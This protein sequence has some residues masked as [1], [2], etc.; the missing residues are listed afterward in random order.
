MTG[1]SRFGAQ[2]ENVRS[3]IDRSQ[4]RSDRYVRISIQAITGEGV[5]R[6]VED[7]H[8]VRLGAPAQQVSVPGRWRQ[9][10]LCF[11]G[12]TT[13]VALCPGHRGPPRTMAMNSAR[14][15]GRLR[16]PARIAE[17]TIV[18]PGFSMPRMVMQV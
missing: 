1:T 15:S 10:E 3:S 5:G 11:F 14:V 16:N 8:D 7:R 13:P 6:E 9:R 4:G 17:V 18:A 2:I 12:K